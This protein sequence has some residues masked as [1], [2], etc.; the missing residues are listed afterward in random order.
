MYAEDIQQLVLGLLAQTEFANAAS[1]AFAAVETIQED[2]DGL[3]Q[4]QD[5]RELLNIKIGTTLLLA[6]LGKAQMGKLPQSFQK[7]DWVDIADSVAAYALR[8]DGKD[9]S[10]FVF[11][12]YANYIDAYTAALAGRISPATRKAI[13]A[14]S[15]E[16]RSR[17]DDLNEG[18]IDE[19][20]YIERC[21]WTSL[22]A[23]IKLLSALLA[24]TSGSTECERLATAVAQLAFEYA[25]LRLYTEEQ[26][27]LDELLAHQAELDEELEAKI[28]A[29]RADLA[30]QSKQFLSLVDNAFSSDIRKRLMGSVTLANSTG[31]EEEKVLDS[32][33]KIDE[34][35]LM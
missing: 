24:S 25:R 14:L 29:F 12:L 28:D 9:Y 7:E 10:A 4:Q 35:F 33:E 31:V 15:E 11:T 8:M 27:L 2:L 6:I 21:L 1:Q 20:A 22:E 3:L 23:I 30:M 16:L 32:V 26:A 13:L 17:T 18:L 5:Q 19:P 34:F